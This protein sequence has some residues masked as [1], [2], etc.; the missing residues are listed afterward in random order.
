MLLASGCGVSPSR[1]VAT[2]GS[3]KSPGKADDSFDQ[4]YTPDQ[5]SRYG[6][7]A[8]DRVWTINDQ[9]NVANILAK[10]TKERGYYL[11]PK[12]KSERSGMIFDRLMSAENFAYFADKNQPIESRLKNIDR[13]LDANCKILTMYLSAYRTK[14]SHV[15]E[16]VEYMGSLMRFAPVILDL[17]NEAGESFS[18]EDSRRF[19]LNKTGDDADALKRVIETFISFLEEPQQFHKTEFRRYVWH[20]NETMP[21]YFK[22][23]P[24]E[25][26]EFLMWRLEKV[27]RIPGTKMLQPELDELIAKLKTLT[28]KEASE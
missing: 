27:Q 9:V 8:Y 15:M 6:M 23:L 22:R 7:P 5:F 4:S 28:P 11:L 24:K 26:R 3:G 25:H 13:Y 10:L 14:D 19:H 1:E 12:Y 17:L 2:S 18:K 21:T 20:L 16:F